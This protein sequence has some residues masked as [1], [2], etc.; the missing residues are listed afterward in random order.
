M[1]FTQASE[2]Y[3]AAVESKNDGQVIQPSESASKMGKSGRW[4][5][6]NTNGFLAYVTSTGKDLDGKYHMV[7]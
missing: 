7:A 6:R 2:K 4:V 1:N 5:L 3:V